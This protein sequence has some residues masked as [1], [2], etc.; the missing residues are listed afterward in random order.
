MSRKKAK[1]LKSVSHDASP[2]THRYLNC[3]LNYRTYLDWKLNPHKAINGKAFT[4]VIDVKNVTNNSIEVDVNSALKSQFYTGKKH[5][6]IKEDIRTDQQ[7][8]ANAGILYIKA[9]GENNNS[10][11]QLRHTKWKFHSKNTIPSS[12]MDTCR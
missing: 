10:V 4:V 7:I 9:L 8:E 6:F 12:R 1:P 2:M 11:F 3:L 5:K